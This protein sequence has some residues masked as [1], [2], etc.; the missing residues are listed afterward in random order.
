MY[1]VEKIHERQ[2]QKVEEIKDLLGLNADKAIL[3][4]RHFKWDLDKLQ[5]NWFE[6]EKHLKLEIGLEFDQ[7]IPKKFSYVNASL[8]AN[9]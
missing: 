3:V 7:S 9:N 4:L 1:T 8:S 6:K 2:M 5:N